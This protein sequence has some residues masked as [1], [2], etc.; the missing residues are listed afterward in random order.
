MVAIY[1][2]KILLQRRSNMV[3]RVFQQIF[4]LLK[5]RQAKTKLLSLVVSIAML[6]FYAALSALAQSGTTKP[7]NANTGSSSPR[8]SSEKLKPAVSSAMNLSLEQILESM[9]KN[10]QKVTNLSGYFL[11]ISQIDSSWLGP[12]AA[13]EVPDYWNGQRVVLEKNLLLYRNGKIMQDSQTIYYNRKG[14]K[15]E[16]RKSWFNGKSSWVMT[17]DAPSVWTAREYRE[18]NSSLADMAALQFEDPKK[19][20]WFGVPLVKMLRQNKVRLVGEETFR[21][22]PCL[23]LQYTH[24]RPDAQVTGTLLVCPSR[25]FSVVT[26]NEK[27]KITAPNTKIASNERNDVVEQFKQYGNQWIPT[28]ARMENYETDKNGNRKRL[29]SRLFKVQ[30]LQIN[31]IED[32]GVFTPQ[33]SPGTDIHRLNANR[34]EVAGGHTSALESALRAGNLSVLEAQKVD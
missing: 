3:F 4:P 9:E 33:F 11:D 16:K 15:E 18:A 31:A 17:Q 21:G 26:H 22:L 13:S 29:Y 23:R 8:E 12:A 32:D 25:D 1:M 6:G 7:T 10:R 19:P 24:L 34:V 30:S 5:C 20:Q 28:V 2:S 27:L 14:A